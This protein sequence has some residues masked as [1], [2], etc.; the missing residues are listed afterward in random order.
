MSELNTQL[1]NSEIVPELCDLCYYP[2]W[3]T[4]DNS[5]GLGNDYEVTLEDFAATILSAEDGCD[6]C[7]LLSRVWKLVI[8][9][10][11]KRQE[12]E[13]HFNRSCEHLWIHIFSEGRVHDIEAMTL[14]GMSPAIRRI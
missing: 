14:H 10:D 3:S 2:S 7:K 4:E 5:L 13:F 8:P 11:S 6:G 1:V 9:D 12:S